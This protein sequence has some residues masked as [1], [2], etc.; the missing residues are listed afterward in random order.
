VTGCVVAGPVVGVCSG[1]SVATGVFSTPVVSQ[2][3]IASAK[4]DISI[5]IVKIIDILLI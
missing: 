4:T 3:L 1:V 5:A 2:E